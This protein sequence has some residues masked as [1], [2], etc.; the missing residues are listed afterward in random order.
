[1]ER[2]DPYNCMCTVTVTAKSSVVLEDNFPKPGDKREPEDEGTCSGI[3]IDSQ[4][5]LVLT[6]ASLIYPLATKIKK[7]KLQ[8]L[9]Q[10][11]VA[12]GNLFKGGIQTTVLLPSQDLNNGKSG[13]SQ[14][15]DKKGNYNPAVLN[16]N[17]DEEFNTLTYNAKLKS[18]FECRPLKRTL[19]R[20]MPNDSWQFIDSVN[21]S[22]DK[23][24]SLE[25]E[26]LF[27]H[28]LPCFVLFQLKNWEPFESDLLVKKG[29]S[30]HLGDP[31]EICATPFGGL[32]PE[33]F[34]NSRARGIISN[35]AG[36]RNVLLLTDARCVP[37]SEGGALFYCKG[38]QR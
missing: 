35:M 9:R 13:D 37:G 6:H 19:H 16:C 34:L 4:K 14:V 2:K 22:N 25:D 5:G 18:V 20:M 38:K 36:P 21:T 26:E 30:N 8:C 10:T 17:F 23:A 11:G 3:I 7:Q 33:V 15:K 27:Y 12:H 29:L 31:I 28:L 24:K 1:M 32:N